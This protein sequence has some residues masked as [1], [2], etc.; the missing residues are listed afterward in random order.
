MR[1][2]FD[3]EFD[4]RMPLLKPPHI[5]VSIRIFDV[6]IAEDMDDLVCLESFSHKIGHHGAVFA[7]GKAYDWLLP[8]IL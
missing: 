2:S 1:C 8:R 3:P 4:L 7:T 5:R 6:C